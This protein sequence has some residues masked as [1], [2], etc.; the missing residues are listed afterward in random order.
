MYRTE[1]EC[2]KIII[3]KLFSGVKSSQIERAVFRAAEYTGQFIVN[4]IKKD[5]V[6]PFDEGD[7][8]LSTTATV[9][10][11]KLVL[12]WNTPYAKRRYYEEANIS[13]SQNVNA[14][15]RWFDAYMNKNSDE[16]KIVYNYFINKL[17]ELL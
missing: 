12:S 17:I 8:Q 16:Y 4:K 5:Q 14:Q 1:E 11:G 15:N 3:N 10:D 9:E 7:L 6:I 13:R 2:Y